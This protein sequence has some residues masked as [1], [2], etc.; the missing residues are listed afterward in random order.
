M[1]RWLGPHERRIQS[2]IRFV[3]SKSRGEIE[4]ARSWKTTLE[5][6]ND[7]DDEVLFNRGR[8][9]R[10]GM[11]S[12]IT[13]PL[14]G[15]LNPQFGSFELGPIHRDR[16]TDAEDFIGFDLIRRLGFAIN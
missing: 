9:L 15:G 1:T 10:S 14:K 13:S 8:R 2:A 7:E 4:A 3:E 6:P 16:V 12:N 11:E 5:S